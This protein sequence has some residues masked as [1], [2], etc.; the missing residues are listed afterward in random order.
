[1]LCRDR[2]HRRVAQGAK[3]VVQLHGTIREELRSIVSLTS[4]PATAAMHSY[5]IPLHLDIAIQLT[6]AIHFAP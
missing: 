2:G 4:L 3:L 1:M 6:H 5:A